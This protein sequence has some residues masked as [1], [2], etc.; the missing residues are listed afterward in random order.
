SIRTTLK[1]IGIALADEAR[2]N[3]AFGVSGGKIGRDKTSVVVV[4]H[5]KSITDANIGKIAKGAARLNQVWRRFINDK[6]GELEVRFWAECDFSFHL[7][8][9]RWCGSQ[10]QIRHRF[11]TDLASIH[12]Y[13]QPARDGG[14][15]PVA[16]NFA[17][18]LPV[19]PEIIIEIIVKIVWVNGR[20]GCC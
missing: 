6:P 20:L 3:F 7:E 15:T 19:W 10:K 16:G 4:V 12:I 2:I 17:Q 13:L 9:P 1:S 14:E 5:I 11:I 18:P 8:V